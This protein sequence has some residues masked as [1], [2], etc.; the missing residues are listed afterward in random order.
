MS[1]RMLP[2]AWIAVIIAGATSAVAQLDLMDRKL[3]KQLGAGYAAMINFAENPDIATARYYIDSDSAEDPTLRV[4]RL[5]GEHAFRRDGQDWYPFLQVHAPYMTYDATVDLGKNGY[6]NSEWD[7]VGAIFTTGLAFPLTTNLF[8][9]PAVATGYVRLEN[10]AHYHGNVEGL[11]PILKGIIFDWTSEAWLLGAALWFDYERR[12]KALEL[13]LHAGA[14]HNLIETIRTVRGD[15]EFSSYA[16]TLSLNGE[17]TY[18][19]SLKPMGYPLSLINML[20]L[21]SF[22]GP[23]RDELGFAYF[24]DAGLAIETDISRHGW[25][26]KRFR[27]GAKGIYGEDVIGWSAILSWKF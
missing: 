3:A 25:I 11:E 1:R 2:F 19:T 24:V 23:Y 22:A 10:R 15:V 27:L 14:S 12:Y 7:T 13:S 18:P 9:K 16:T 5:S 21:T 4:L 17:T 6:I 26:V 8:I 20:G